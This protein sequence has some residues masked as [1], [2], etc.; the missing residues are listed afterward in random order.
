M[1]G[2]VTAI[3]SA[4]QSSHQHH[5]HHYHRKRRLREV[6][7][8]PGLIYTISTSVQHIKPAPPLTLQTYLKKQKN[9]STYF[10]SP[11]T[12]KL[13]FL[14]P[15][16]PS[17]PFRPLFSWLQNSGKEKSGCWALMAPTHHSS[18]SITWEVKLVEATGDRITRDFTLITPLLPLP[19]HSLHTHKCS[20]GEGYGPTLKWSPSLSHLYSSFTRS[21]WDTISLQLQ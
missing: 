10:T 19:P 21:Q 7:S 11:P 5:P 12:P 2:W 13:Y 1:S 14:P 8:S 9:K 17:S 20:E 6:A 16:H 18:V 3:S 15:I 4:A